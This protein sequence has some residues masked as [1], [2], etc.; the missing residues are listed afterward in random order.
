MNQKAHKT[1]EALNIQEV[2]NIHKAIN[3]H[4]APVALNIRDAQIIH[5]TCGNQYS[6][7]LNKATWGNIHFLPLH[8][9][10]R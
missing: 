7:G 5:E 9:T 2:P 6:G 10:H 3:M 4:E 1:H 8:K